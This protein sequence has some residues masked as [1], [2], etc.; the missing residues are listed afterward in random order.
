[1][2]NLLLSLYDALGLELDT[3]EPVLWVDE[4]LAIYFEET[5]QGL[6]MCCP[7]GALPDDV[8]Q[9]K[10]LLQRNYV[11]PVVLAADADST[12]LL[13]LLRA[14]EDSEGV[15]LLAMLELL[16]SSARGLRDE[17]GLSNQHRALHDEAGSTNHR[18]LPNTPG[19][20][21]MLA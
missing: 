20:V 8:A 21:G 12:L 15:D 13:A 9:L 14:P 1:M 2:D 6:E 19:L 7:L 11:D 18:E 3:E 4:D 16:I 17:L 10:R 5:P